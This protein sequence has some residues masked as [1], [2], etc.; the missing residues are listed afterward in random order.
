MPLILAD[1][2][3]VLKNPRNLR[4]LRAGLKIIL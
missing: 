1:E 3:W 4:N 2:D